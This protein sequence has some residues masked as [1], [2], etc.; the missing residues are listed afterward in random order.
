M[1]QSFEVRTTRCLK[2]Y[3]SKI[4]FTYCLL[5]YYNSCLLFN[6]KIINP[7]ASS[8]RHTFFISPLAAKKMK[9]YLVVSI[10]YCLQNIISIIRDYVNSAII[11]TMDIIY[12]PIITNPSFQLLL[13]QTP[14]LKPRLSNPPTSPSAFQI[15]T[16]PRLIKSGTL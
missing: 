16:S 8:N 13:P 11:S 4:K 14:G 12:N 1:S 15:S 2:K 3:K 9:Y 7:V 6:S 10:V 5:C